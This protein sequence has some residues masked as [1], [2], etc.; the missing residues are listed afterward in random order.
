[1]G[2]A[3]VLLIGLLI[4]DGMPTGFQ[5]D[6]D[7]IV[8]QQTSNP[9]SEVKINDAIVETDKYESERQRK[10]E[11]LEP[12]EKNGS[13]T[14]S[15]IATIHDNDASNQQTSAGTNNTLKNFGKNDTRSIPTIKS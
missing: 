15:K 3:A 11:Y 9:N 5:N 8:N 4:F 12:V 10:L 1:A 14:E 7:V 6:S 13:A 2:V